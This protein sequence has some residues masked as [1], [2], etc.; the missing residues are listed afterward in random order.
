MLNAMKSKK[1][2]IVIG[3]TITGALSGW[4]Y[5]Q[6]IGYDNKNPLV[7]SPVICIVVGAVVF[8]TLAGIF[9]STPHIEA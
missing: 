1:W 2:L 9:I 6:Q 7:H 3:A 4:L 8:G 5:W